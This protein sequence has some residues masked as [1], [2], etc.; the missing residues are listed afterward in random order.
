MGYDKKI[1]G[2]AC[3]LT[4]QRKAKH[5]HTSVV[6][7]LVHCFDIMIILLIFLPKMLD[8]PQLQ[9]QTVQLQANTVRLVDS[10]F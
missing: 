1:N 5:E 9:L 4:E 6:L 8:L 10:T 7:H 3:T 2:N